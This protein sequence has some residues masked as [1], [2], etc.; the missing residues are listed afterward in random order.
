MRFPLQRF[1]SSSAGPIQFATVHVL[2]DLVSS[3]FGGRRRA[4]VCGSAAT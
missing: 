4:T 3:T 2:G 1:D